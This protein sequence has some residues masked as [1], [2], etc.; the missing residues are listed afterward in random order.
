MGNVPHARLFYDEIQCIGSNH[1]M[2]PFRCSET[3]VTQ[4]WTK[5]PASHGKKLFLKKKNFRFFEG[6]KCP[7]KSW[8]FR[9][10]LRST[11]FWIFF[12]RKKYFRNFER[13]IFLRIWKL[14]EFIYFI[15]IYKS[16]TFWSK[17]SVLKL[18]LGL[19]KSIS[20]N[21][22]DTIIVCMTRGF[23]WHTHCS[24]FETKDEIGLFLWV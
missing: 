8:I 11:S 4:T 5:S 14:F 23:S 20:Q 22:G 16:E 1:M 3:H 6:K 13:S 15:S 19:K 17:M 12:E 10:K 9:K 2:L 18:L 21:V 7:K 24:L